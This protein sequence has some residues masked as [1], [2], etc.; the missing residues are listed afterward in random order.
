MEKPRLMARAGASNWIGALLGWLFTT[1][2]SK[3]YR[4]KAEARH[5]RGELRRRGEL[6]TRRRQRIRTVHRD[7]KPN[8]SPKGIDPD[9]HN[10]L[11]ALASSSVAMALP[12]YS[13]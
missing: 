4:R 8:E 13:R 2:A 6:R 10:R 1:D 3:A 12:S 7:H 9:L 5:I 11:C